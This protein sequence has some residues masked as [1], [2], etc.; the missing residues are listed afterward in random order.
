MKATR[1]LPAVLV[2]L[3]A[4]A[5]PPRTPQ[6]FDNHA[7]PPGRYQEAR[8]QDGGDVAIRELLVRLEKLEPTIDSDASERDALRIV[9]MLAREA[10]RGGLAQVCEHI[11]WKLSGSTKAA[12]HEAYLLDFLTR[13]QEVVFEIGGDDAPT[14]ENLG[15]YSINASRRSPF[16]KILIDKGSHALRTLKTGGVEYAALVCT[17]LER[18]NWGA[19]SRI[20]RETDPESPRFKKS[21]AETLGLYRDRLA[22]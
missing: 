20:R 1:T 17:I 6:W 11:V 21:T 12:R 10:Q 22:R 7:T 5:S 16:L 14:I 8:F 2:L 4:C 19:V 15:A 3:S 9:R 13:C 18:V